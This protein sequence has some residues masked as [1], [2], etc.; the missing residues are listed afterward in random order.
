MAY[1]T[2]Y[3]AKHLLSKGALFNFVE[4][5]RSDGKTF[6]IKTRTLYDKKEKGL[7]SIY[8]RRFKSEI[9]EGLYSNFLGKFS[10]TI[11]PKKK[12]IVRTLKGGNLRV[13]EKVFNVNVPTLTSGNG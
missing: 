8:M 10:V 5:D 11:I 13:H 12:N 3:T 7:I 1:K 2:Y 9:D 4:S 6:D